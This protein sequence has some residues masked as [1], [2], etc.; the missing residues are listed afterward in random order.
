M[1]ILITGGSGFIGTNLV[2][3]L[4]SLKAFEI[5]N[6]DVK[7]PIESQLTYWRFCDILNPQSVSDAFNFFKPDSVIHLAARTDTDPKNTLNDYRVNT[8]GTDNVINAIKQCDSIKRVIITSTQFVHQYK[9]L[10]KNDEDYAPHT[11]YGESKVIMERATR[12]ANLTCT[13]TIIRPTNIWGPWHLRYPH[14]FWKVLSM[15]LYFHPGKKPVLRS[16]G[17]VGNVVF[18]IISILQSSVEKVNCKVY[19]VGDPPIDLYDWVNGFS[20]KQTGKK[21]KII[22]RKFVRSIALMGDLLALLRIK[23]PLTSSRYKSMTSNNIS[24]IE[25]TISAF[26]VPPFSLEQ[27]IEESVNWMRKVHPDL[28]KI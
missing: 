22:P 3:K 6:I 10:P 14:E 27:G 11:V 8:E 5:L 20:I 28:V 4:A 25:N 23:F 1:K 7:K 18:Q 21:V 12:S 9:G 2:S 17:Y 13:W 16:Y 19:Y 15:G 24:P 26:G